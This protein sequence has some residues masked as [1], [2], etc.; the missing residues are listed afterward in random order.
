LLKKSS[1]IRSSSSK[2]YFGKFDYIPTKYDKASTLSKGA[3]E[4]DRMKIESF[5]RK[6][7]ISSSRI[8]QKYEDTF[9]DKNYRY[10][11]CLGPGVGIKGLDS[12]VRSDFS[13]MSKFSCGKYNGSSTM[14]MVPSTDAIEISKKVRIQ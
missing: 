12:V 13:D 2:A 9:E 10:P 5:C 11:N 8:K 6:P 4:A 14:S 1:D 3:F 7:I